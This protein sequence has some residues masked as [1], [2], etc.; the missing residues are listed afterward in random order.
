M[1]FFHA[2]YSALLSKAEFNSA[3]NSGWIVLIV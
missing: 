3:V 1:T 2:E